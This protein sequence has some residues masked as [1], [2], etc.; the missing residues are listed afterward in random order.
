MGRFSPQQINSGN[1]ERLNDNRIKYSENV[2]CK[3]D[4]DDESDRYSDDELFDWLEYEQRM[5]LSIENSGIK[6]KEGV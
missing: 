2:M 1:T 6:N 3:D 4:D 5:Y